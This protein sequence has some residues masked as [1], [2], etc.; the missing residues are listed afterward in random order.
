V[1][2]IAVVTQAGPIKGRVEVVR[3]CGFKSGA[4]F[5]F[6]FESVSGIGGTGYDIELLWPEAGLF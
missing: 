4:L 5:E 3:V 2:K 1:R 6:V